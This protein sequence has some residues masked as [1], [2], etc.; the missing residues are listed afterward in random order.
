VPDVWGSVAAMFV[1]ALLL[2]A[3]RSLF[4]RS[5]ILINY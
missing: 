3:L 1:M 4:E 2:V 5:V